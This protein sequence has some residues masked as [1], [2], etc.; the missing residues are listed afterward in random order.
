MAATIK[1]LADADRKKL[2]EKIRQTFKKTGSIRATARALSMCHKTI[3]RAIQ[4]FDMPRKPD[5][6]KEIKD[7]QQ[8]AAQ[9]PI[10]VI[11]RT[12][13]E[14]KI[15]R[16][17]AENKE[18][19]ASLKDSLTYEEVRAQIFKLATK[20]PVM[21]EWASKPRGKKE[22]NKVVPIAV[23]SDLHY[24]EVVELPQVGY[25]NQFNVET[26][27]KRLQEWVETLIALCYDYE[28]EPPNYDGIVVCLG[29]DMIS[30]DIHD[31]L[32]ASN[33]LPS[34]GAVMR[35]AGM[36]KKCLLTIADKFGNVVVPCVTGNHGRITHKPQAKNY[37]EVNFETLLY[38]MLEREL[39]SDKRFNFI[40][41]DDT[42]VHFTVYGTNYALT[43]GNFMG[44]N[45]GH[46]IIGSIGPIT[47]GAQK[48]ILSEAS[49]PNPI[50]V[51]KVIMGHWHT[52]ME[53]PNAFV[54][55]SLKGYDEYAQNFLRAKF[56]P[57]T[58]IV[59]REHQQRGPI[60]FEKIYCDADMADLKAKPSYEAIIS[61]PANR[62]ND[63]GRFNPNG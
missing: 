11:E 54:N 23:L 17:N 22:K 29:G 51:D 5:Q 1:K 33:D 63:F 61:T 13:F 36:L 53:L 28:K 38:L 20:R 46:G 37:N 40:F 24:G 8:A 25:S 57:P 4:D 14:R 3:S 58:Q 43:H 48:I 47:R 50:R 31:E 32:K 52:A 45:G 30:G 62:R 26:A 9:Q 15:E 16:L 7:A 2:L 12:K 10:D 60:R 41:P 35:L 55:G 19:R 21:P 49:K 39:E 59:W 27:E 44:V 42:V 6:Y 18:L 34:L 56:E